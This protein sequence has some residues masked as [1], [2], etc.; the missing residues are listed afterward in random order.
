MTKMPSEIKTRIQGK[1]PLIGSLVTLPSAD[2]A[3]IMS[4]VGWDYLWID[5][6]HTTLDFLQVQRMVQAVAGRCPCLVRVPE[7]SEVW[8]KKALDVGCDGIVVPQVKSA[9]EAQR[10]VDWSF[11]PPIGKR[12][13]GV[14]RAHGYGMEFDDYVA[15]IN[16]DLVIVLQIEHIVAVENI[17][18]ILEVQ[19]IDALLIG[20]LDLSGS[21]G[22]IG[23]TDSP[24]VQEAI[25]RVKQACEA[26]GMSLGIFTPD[27]ASAQDRLRE[28]FSLIALNMDAA[29]LW[30]AARGALDEVRGSTDM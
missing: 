10:V 9:E 26:A 23:Q 19:G 7:N 29:F 28:G 15:R 11:Y 1:E 13:A 16:D 20:P 4:L 24:V 14:S 8:I 17:E 27:P 3:E 6:E 2:I 30:Q 21:M 25:E 18:R 22:V 5:T 12:G